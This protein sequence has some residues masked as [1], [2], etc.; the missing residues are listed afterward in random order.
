MERNSEV[1]RGIDLYPVNS[2]AHSETKIPQEVVSDNN[3][4]VS[5]G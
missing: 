1:V 2:D 4:V 3:K 5:H